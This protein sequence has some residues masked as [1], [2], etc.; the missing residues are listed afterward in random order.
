MVFWFELSQQKS[1]HFMATDYC[2][3]HPLVSATWHCPACHIS[4]CDD[5]TH[6]TGEMENTPNCLLC[7]QPLTSISHSAAIAPFWQH[8]TDFMRL[9]FNPMGILCLLIMVVLPTLA[10]SGLL[11]PIAGGAYFVLALYGWALLQHTATG[12]LKLPTLQNISQSISK[13]A[14][15]V[16]ALVALVF[17]L[18]GVLALKS[19]VAAIVISGL[20]LVLAPVMLM[21]VAIDKSMS[22]LWQHHAW[23]HI[24]GAMQLMYV[25]LAGI[26][27]VLFSVIYAVTNIMADILPVGGLQGL[28]QGL[29]GYGLWVMMAVT[30]YALFQFQKPLHFEVLG[31][32]NK[33]RVVNRKLDNQAAR[34]EVYL[35]EGLYDRAA[36]L[37]KVVAEKQKKNP[38][39]QERYYQ[40]LVFM[41]DKEQIP[42]QATSYLEALLETG[43]H[44]LALQVLIKLQFLIPDFRPQ[45]PDMCFE[46]AKA[47]AEQ[48]DYPRA[49]S[50]LRDMHKDSPHYANL[51]E[52]YLLLAKLLYDKMNE[53][54][55]ALE[56]LEYLVLRFK[57]HPRHPQIEH[58]WRQLGGKPKNDF[59]D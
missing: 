52:A 13:L 39:I 17:V 44:S 26:A 11:L 40:L 38:E 9:A 59:M 25:P 50:L 8:Y 33:K 28:K 7:N 43:Q 49:V 46:L 23:L 37:M 14:L 10:P 6:M 15:E 2:K 53:K 12:N 35:K 45:T 5:C 56:I 55:D 4:V 34:L 18:L 3:Y 20:L 1:M 24:W 27:V 41:Q 51:P 16:S 19:V 48:K 57:K 47:C 31:K 58:F 22:S 30:G 32:K 42:Y 36:A 54:H 21:A 29:Y